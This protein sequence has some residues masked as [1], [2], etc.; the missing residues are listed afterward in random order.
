MIL[1]NLLIL[2][3]YLITLTLSLYHV[4][5]EKSKILSFTSILLR[6]LGLICIQRLEKS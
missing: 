2:N 6:S 5:L 4:F 1:I 3:L